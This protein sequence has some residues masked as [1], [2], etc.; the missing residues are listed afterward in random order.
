MFL[1]F[2]CL[3]KISIFAPLTSSMRHP[4]HL[5]WYPFR[6]HKSRFRCVLCL[7]DEYLAEELMIER[8]KTNK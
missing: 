2:F 8:N 6:V 7:S 1:L 4:N 3:K 5:L